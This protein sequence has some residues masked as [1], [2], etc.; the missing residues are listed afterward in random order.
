MKFDAHIEF[1]ITARTTR[2]FF[3][4]LPEILNSSGK[5]F[6]SVEPAKKVLHDMIWTAQ[7]RFIEKFRYVR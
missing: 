7:F 2:L 1:L 4:S 6:V 3:Y 5:S